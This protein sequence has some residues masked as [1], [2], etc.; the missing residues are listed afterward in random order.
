VIEPRNAY[1]LKPSLSQKW[2][3]HRCDRQ[4]KGTSVRP[5]SRSGAKTRDG[6][7]GDLRDP[8]G[9][10]VSEPELRGWPA[11]KTR[12]REGTSAPPGARRR[13][14]RNGEHKR[15]R[16]HV[17]GGS[18]QRW[19]F[20]N[21]RNPNVDRGPGPGRVPSHPEDPLRPAAPVH[22][23]LQRGRMSDWSPAPPTPVPYSGLATVVV[24]GVQMPLHGLPA[25]AMPNGQ[26]RP[27]RLGRCWVRRFQ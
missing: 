24:H 11:S 26:Q 9:V 27:T 23:D 14:G 15:R 18:E 4:G 6:S 12:G 1:R 16:D 25:S 17:G 22:G 10:H 13:L 5:G 20:K 2:G 3:Q 19:H 8:I 7:P 21:P